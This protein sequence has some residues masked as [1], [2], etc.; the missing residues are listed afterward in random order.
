MDATSAVPYSTS[1]PALPAIDR[2][3]ASAAFVTPVAGVPLLDIQREIAGL[4][5]DLTRAID[6]VVQSGRFVLGP[7]C[8]RFE[9]AFADFLGVPFAIGCASGSDALLLPLMACDVGPGDE[10][11]V[12]SFTF[13]ATASAVARVGATPVFVDID[14]ASYTLQPEL[15]ARAISSR[16]KA[17]VP[18]HLFGHPAD[19]TAIRE[20]ADQ[21]DLRV[22]EDCAQSIASAHR[23][24]F[25]G[26]TGHFGCFSFYPT[27]NLGCFGDSGLM[28][29]SDPE[30]AVRLKRLRAHGMEPRY[31]HHEIG[32]NSRLDSIQ[33]AILHTKLPYLASWNATRRSHA[34]RYAQLFGEAGLERYLG[35]PQEVPGNH[36]TWN[37]YTIRVLGGHRDALRAALTSRR[38]GTEI[39]YPIPLHRQTCFG[40]LGAEGV[41][42]P[43]TERAAGEVLSLPIFPQMTIPEQDF[44]VQAISEFFG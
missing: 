27:K 22:I 41:C 7:A 19:L 32:I 23:G 43:E 13:F 17:I 40:Y 35:L 6:D 42:L 26:S 8:E 10:V 30:F 12:P 3:A 33:A 4:Q 1:K 29:T 18:V 39:Y 36:H 24:Q 25:V 31:V 44:V 37:Q 11:I 34:A 21:H 28:T 20:I 38:I 16:T 15:V 5:S 9:A 14:P 2:E